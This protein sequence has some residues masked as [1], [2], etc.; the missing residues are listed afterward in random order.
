MKSLFSDN[1]LANMLHL[2]HNTQTM[3]VNNMAAKLRVSDRTIRNDI[4]QLNQTL[5]L[6]ADRGIPGALHAARF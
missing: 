1:R 4:K 5:R 3:S 2:F 6:R